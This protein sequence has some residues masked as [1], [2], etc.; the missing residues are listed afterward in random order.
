MKKLKLT[1]AIASILIAVLV[2]A[3]NSIGVNAEWKQ[4]SIEGNIQN[5]T[6]TF[7]FNNPEIIQGNTSSNIINGGIATIQDD[8]IYYKGNDSNNTEKYSIN[9][10]KTDGSQK[11]EIKNDLS[12]FNNLNVTGD[13]IYYYT[14]NPDTKKGSIN[15]IKTDGSHETE[16]MH[17]DSERLLNYFDNLNVVGD[18]IYYKEKKTS[19]NAYYYNADYIYSINKI[20]TDGSQKTEIISNSDGIYDLNVVGDY[21]YYKTDDSQNHINKIKTDGSQ[22]TEIISDSDSIYNLNV[23]GDWIYYYRYNL[24]TNTYSINKV[25]IDGSQKTEII[26]GSHHMYDLNVVGDWIYYDC[27][28]DTNNSNK[29]IYSISKIK[30]DGTQ[31]TE[32]LNGSDNIYDLSVSDLNIVGDWIYYKETKSQYNIGKYIN[33]I[34]KIKTDASQN[35]NA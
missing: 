20:K 13:W 10:I 14:W 15:K 16:I 2:L 12:D 19:P 35:S 17:N 4:N 11:T 25:K 23:V 6:D 21:I 1:K 31:K 18:W 24:N 7:F 27:N 9:K 22:K 29:Y 32:I 34:N 28:L 5:G 33:S 30:T 26:S 3:I 8:W